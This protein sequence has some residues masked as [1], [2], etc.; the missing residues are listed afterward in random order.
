M[1]GFSALRCI[2]RRSRRAPARPHP[3]APGAVVTLL[4]AFLLLGAGGLAAQDAVA[5]TAF[6]WKRARLRTPRTPRVRSRK[7]L[8]R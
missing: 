4:G 8:P 6:G 7:L 3:G 2:R 1:S 5:D